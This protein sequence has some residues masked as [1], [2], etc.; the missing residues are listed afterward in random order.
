MLKYFGCAYYPE[1]WP[2]ERHETDLEMMKRAGFNVVRIGEFAWSS[3][4][5]EEGRFEF[6]WLRRVLDKCRNAGIRVM[7]CTPS[8]TPPAWACRKYPAIRLVRQN[9]EVFPMGIRRHYCVG[10][11]QYRELLTRFIS[12]IAAEFAAHP[13]VFA[14]QIDNEIALAETG[15]CFCP[16]CQELFREWLKEKY[17]TLEKLNRA[18]GNAFWSSAFSDWSEIVPPFHR[19]S[20][21]LDWSRFQ[22]H[23]FSRFIGFQT[24][25]LRQAN[26]DW[27]VTT[28]SWISLAPELDPAVLFSGLDVAAYDCYVNVYENLQAYRACWELYRNMKEK[29]LP[30]WLTETGAWN[31]V[32]GDSRSYDALRVWAWELFGRGCE[33]LF[34]FRWRQSL[35]GEEDHPAILPWDGSE[36]TP[37]QAI[38]EIGRELEKYSAFEAL[39]L[40]QA[41]VAILIEPQAAVMERN[42]NVSTLSESIVILHGK[43]DSLGVASD[44]LPA[45][46]ERD[47]KKYRLVILPQTEYV[48]PVLAERLAGFVENGGI[49]FAQERLSIL[50]EYGKY[51]PSASP[52][53]LEDLFGIRISERCLIRSVP[54]HPPYHRGTESAERTVSRISGELFGEAVSFFQRMEKICVKDAEVPGNYTSGVF[55]G[56]PCFTE[57]GYGR[58][59][60]C[61]LG[62]LP[63]DRGTLLI[64]RRLLSLA[65]IRFLPVPLAEECCILKRGNI[66]FYLNPSSCARK[67]PLLSGGRCLIGRIEDDAVPLG[68]Y[69]LAV[70]EE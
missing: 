52:A 25:L 30:F 21:Q 64:L 37:Y 48:S 4:E 65:E 51:L 3:L 35:M 57:K 47:L 6:G 63:D 32:T 12:R 53:G 19:K 38:C 58:G 67:L 26:P 27:L 20:W 5:P 44:I 70:V 24:E 16:H 10:S 39:P 1:A 46:T 54:A 28:N 14:W 40:P 2:E 8:A 15:A 56:E 31:P 18:W 22:T 45:N 41:D 55:A 69:D 50:D 11:D 34:Y 33:G 61:Y 68:P 29:P 36:S 42:R 7:L 13:A 43:L 23:L 66:R 17:G 49:L 60:A 59:R 62:A 9:G